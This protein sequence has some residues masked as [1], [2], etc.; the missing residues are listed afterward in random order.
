MLFGAVGDAA[1]QLGSKLSVNSQPTTICPALHP[2]RWHGRACSTQPQGHS[3]CAYWHFC[4]A[5]PALLWECGRASASNPGLR[6]MTMD[7]H[8]TAAELEQ[9]I[10]DLEQ[11][12]KV[13]AFIA[14]ACT[15][16]YTQYAGL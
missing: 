14:A 6:Q 15:S 7:L 8:N 2:D 1:W 10:L 5:M 16:I 13:C 11:A 9:T 3:V 4:Y 12:K